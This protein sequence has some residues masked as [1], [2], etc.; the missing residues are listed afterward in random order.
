[1]DILFTVCGRAGSKG[2]KNKNIKEFL[3]YPLPY[4]T[5]SAIAQ[6]LEEYSEDAIDVALNT[7]SPELIEIAN[8]NPFV[9]VSIINRKPELGG[10]RVPK[11]AVI[12]DTFSQ[13]QEKKKKKYNMVVDL[14]LTSPLRTAK[15]IDKLIKKQ[16]EKEA[17]VT[18]SVTDSRRNPYF[19]MVMDSDKGVKKVLQSDFVARQQAPAVYDM[20]ASLYAY[21]PDFLTS[22][23]GVLD[24]YCEVIKM[25]DTGIL[26]LDHENDFELMQVIADYLFKS[27]EGFQNAFNYLVGGTNKRY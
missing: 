25:F 3:G 15:D 5:F 14:D 9:D 4:Y 27:K 24:G 16:K 1:M 10:D 17:D 20:N 21:N 13:M 8:N 12:L 22:G 23:K 2:I 11:M 26:D 19:N 7:D 18:F 6:Y